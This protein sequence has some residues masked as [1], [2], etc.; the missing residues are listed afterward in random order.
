MAKTSKPKP[1]PKPR[2]R[3]EHEEQLLEQMLEAKL[4]TPIREYALIPGRR[5]RADFAWPMFRVAV[6]VQGGIF[7]RGGGAHSRPGKIMQDMEKHRLATL[8]DWR[9]FP[10]ATHHIP[11]GQALTL[12]IELFDRIDPSRRGTYFDIEGE[13]RRQTAKLHYELTGVIDR[14]QSFRIRRPLER[15]RDLLQE[16]IDL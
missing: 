2:K 9:L 1:P 11:N 12:I 5:F 3:N 13:T 8:Y 4:P 14:T 15:A 10:V 16:A 7:R 6:E